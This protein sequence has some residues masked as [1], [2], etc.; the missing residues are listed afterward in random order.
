MAT[1]KKEQVKK[2]EK[3]RIIIHNSPEPGGKEDVFVSINGKSYNIKREK[4]VEVPVAVLGVLD[5][6]VMILYEKDDKGKLVE[7][8]VKRFSY[9]IVEKT[10]SAEAEKNK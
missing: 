7:K 8:T 5:D 6:A 9:S 1:P 3:K 4:E 2:T 10:A